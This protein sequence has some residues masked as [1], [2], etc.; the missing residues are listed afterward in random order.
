[1]LCFVC[2]FVA[3]EEEIERLPSRASPDTLRGHAE[4]SSDD[5]AAAVSSSTSSSSSSYDKS[6]TSPEVLQPSECRS[7]YLI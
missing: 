6:Q 4:V 2:L 1:M 3:V 5:K 7:G